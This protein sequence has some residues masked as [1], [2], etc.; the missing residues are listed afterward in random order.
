MRSRNATR[1]RRESSCLRCAFSTSET[2]LV[3]F[4]GKITAVVT[5]SA[6]DGREQ[7]ACVSSGKGVGAVRG[8]RGGK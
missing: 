6:V 8:A 3:A 2:L 7:E 1:R 5:T 4:G